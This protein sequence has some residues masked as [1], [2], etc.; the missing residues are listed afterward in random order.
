[1]TSGKDAQKLA[2]KTGGAGIAIPPITILVFAD[3]GALPQ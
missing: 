3:R 2:L 1:M